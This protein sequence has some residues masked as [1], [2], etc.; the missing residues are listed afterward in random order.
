MRSKYGVLVENVTLW[1]HSVWNF[2]FPSATL[3]HRFQLI[4]DNSFGYYDSA[5]SCELCDRM[6]NYMEYVAKQGKPGTC[7]TNT[8]LG[9]LF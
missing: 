2:Y 6:L 1:Y 4:A 9:Y 5:G 8:E 3:Y 7:G